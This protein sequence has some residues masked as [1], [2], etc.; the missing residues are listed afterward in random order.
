MENRDGRPSAVWTAVFVWRRSHSFSVSSLA[1]VATCVERIIISVGLW[2]SQW[3]RTT[4][5]ASAR[6]RLGKVR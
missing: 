3:K 6:G 2:P 1:R 5:L 4:S